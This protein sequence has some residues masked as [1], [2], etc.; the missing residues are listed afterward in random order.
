[1]RFWEAKQCLSCRAS[2]FREELARVHATSGDGVTSTDKAANA[3]ARAASLCPPRVAVPV[4][5]ACLPKA[6]WGRRARSSRDGSIPPRVADADESSNR[7]TQ[8]RCRPAQRIVSLVFIFP[9]DEAT[10]CVRASTATDDGAFF[11]LPSV[12]LQPSRRSVYVSQISAHDRLEQ[13]LR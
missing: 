8:T 5:A 13:H 2:D 9:T 11:A 6:A 12:H 10:T 1:M 4:L 3:M 7:R